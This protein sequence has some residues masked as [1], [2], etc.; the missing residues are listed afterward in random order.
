MSALG[1]N[2]CRD[3]CYLIEWLLPALFWEGEGALTGSVWGVAPSSGN[4]SGVYFAWLPGVPVPA[5][6]SQQAC[7]GANGGQGK[8]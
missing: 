1:S 5:I 7:Q 6:A 2:R 8:L 4:K 3:V